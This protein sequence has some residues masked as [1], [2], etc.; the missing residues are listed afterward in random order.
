MEQ[1][2]YTVIVGTG[3]YIPPKRIKNNAFLNHEFYDADGNKIDLSNEEIIK[4]FEEITEIRERR[5]VEDNQSA[6][7]IAYLAAKDAL[8]SS[9]VDK[10][11]LD[12]IL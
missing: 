1:D 9:G 6:S 8:D 12:Y 4:K 3:S 2:I 11:T 7:D 10:E 5:Y